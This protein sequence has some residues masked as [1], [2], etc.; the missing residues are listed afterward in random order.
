[1]DAT[2]RLPGSEVQGLRV[3]EQV[4]LASKNL[5]HGLE[6]LLKPA[7]VDGAEFLLLWN[8]AE[9]RQQSQSEL[10]DRLGC[11]NAQ[12]SQLSDQL[13]RRGWL[14]AERD[15]RDRRRQHW[16][17]TDLGSQILSH[18]QRALLQ[19]FARLEAA[20]G[21]DKLSSFTDALQR[22]I[23]VESSE[24]GSFPATSQREAA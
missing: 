15:L 23:A 17:L 1:M 11:S 21:P 18:A 6:E 14:V 9:R 19:W 12:I 22:L 7:G 20:V 8:I 4:L 3:V 13:R 16:T 10:A 5:R 24:L 2:A